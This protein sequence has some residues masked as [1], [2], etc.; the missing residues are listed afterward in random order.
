MKK[1]G[2]LVAVI[3]I[4]CPMMFAQDGLFDINLNFAGKLPKTTS[5][6]G[7]EQRPTS[8]AGF[9]GTI[10]VR[11]HEKA[12]L[13]F[14]WEATSDTQKYATGGLFYQ[15]ETDV[16]ELT[17]AFVFHPARYGKWEPFFL[18]GA[19][20]LSFGPTASVIDGIT[21]P[22]GAVRQIQPAVLYGAG[23]DYRITPN[24]AFR[25]QYR[26]LF[27][28]PPNFKVPNIFTGGHGHLAEPTIGIAINF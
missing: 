1:T 22:V 2:L 17:G 6:N 10:G 28:Q 9:L 3:V 19:G 13:Q 14:N 5:G 26:G 20:I 8:S 4:L 11:I 15:I 23:T 16:R 25:L 21:T 18:G 12:S 24:V 7:I 27:Y